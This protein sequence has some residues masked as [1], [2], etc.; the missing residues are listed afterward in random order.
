MWRRDIHARNSGVT[1]S[2]TVWEK[3]NTFTQP[4]GCKGC[5]FIARYSSSRRVKCQSGTPNASCGDIHSPGNWEIMLSRSWTGG[6]EVACSPNLLHGLL[7]RTNMLIDICVG[8]NEMRCLCL[9]IGSSNKTSRVIKDSFRGCHAVFYP[10]SAERLPSSTSTETS[11]F[12]T[13]FYLL[14]YTSEPTAS[15]SG[16]AGCINTHFRK[17]KRLA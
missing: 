4:E 5:D 10:F 13:L 15:N 12:Q 16:Y 17:W 11:F 2:N 14:L 3:I 9:N 7:S 8:R 6:G 1:N